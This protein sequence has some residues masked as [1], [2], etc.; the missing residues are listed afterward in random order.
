MVMVSPLVGSQIRNSHLVLVA[1]EN[2]L[3]GVEWRRESEIKP[4]GVRAGVPLPL[5]SIPGSHNMLNPELLFDRISLAPRDT[6]LRS[7]VRN[8]P[9]TAFEVYHQLHFKGLSEDQVLEAYPELE[10]EDFAAVEAFILAQIRARTHDEITHRRI[11]P[12]E[13]LKHGV[14][15]KGSVPE[16]DHRE[17]ECEKAVLLPLATEV[18]QCLHSDDQVPN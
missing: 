11:L 18:R 4:G 9:L 10:R 6:L 7:Q 2:A 14:Y 16:C 13:E 15:Y 1:H 12:K 3:Y 5:S 17:M 8:L